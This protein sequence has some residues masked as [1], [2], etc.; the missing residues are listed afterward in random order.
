M[1]VVNEEELVES[2]RAG[3]LGIDGVKENDEWD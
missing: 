3:L 2:G 1:I